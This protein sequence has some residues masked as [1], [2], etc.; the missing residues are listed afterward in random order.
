MSD[1]TGGVEMLAGGSSTR[2]TYDARRR[3]PPEE[4]TIEVR[5]GWREKSPLFRVSWL[6]AD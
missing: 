5:N 3:A 4:D 6:L 2:N 1:S